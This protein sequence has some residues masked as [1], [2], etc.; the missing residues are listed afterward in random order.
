[1]I[2]HIVFVCTGNICRS[3]M[4]EGLMRHKCKEAARHDLTVSSMGIHGL[5]DYPATEYAQ[6]V[7]EDDGFDISSH[8]ARYLMGDELQKADLILCMEPVHI[9]FIETFFPWIR[10]KV[11]L[12]GAW[13][14]KANRKSAIQDPMGGSYEKYQQ[15]YNLIK[16]HIERIFPLL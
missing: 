6:K 15:V 8:R 4:A 11:F 13:P 10:E 3:P 5:N 2:R 16:G 14:E 1:M 12:L 7:C 9:K